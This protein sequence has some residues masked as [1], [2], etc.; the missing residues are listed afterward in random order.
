MTELEPFSESGESVVLP[1]TASL[2]DLSDGAACAEA[3]DDLRNLENLIREAKGI[4]TRA[5]VQHS[6][7]IGLLTFELPDGRKV[8]V[9][10]RPDTVYD[11]EE[12]EKGLREAGMSEQRIREIVKEEVSYKVVAKE[13][14][15]AAA[16]NAEYAKV[17]EANRTE[18][19][20]TPSVTLRRR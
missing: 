19:P 15:K 2:V 13:A 8:E 17:V 3:L 4:L 7:E 20:R 12:I 6:E 18:M 11:A 14:K 1:G 9:T 5:I 10:T 16:A